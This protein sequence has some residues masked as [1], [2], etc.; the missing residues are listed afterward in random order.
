MFGEIELIPQKK[1]YNMQNVNVIAS[2]AVVLQWLEY[3]VF[4]YPEVVFRDSLNT[5]K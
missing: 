1:F 5:N 3:A 4:I 2:V